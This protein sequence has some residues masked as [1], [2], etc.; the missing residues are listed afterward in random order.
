MIV[1]TFNWRPLVANVAYN[2]CTNTG[3]YSIFQRS[4]L[5]L[6]NNYQYNCNNTISSVSVVILF[7]W[8]GPSVQKVLR[9]NC[10]LCE[11]SLLELWRQPYHLRPQ[12]EGYAAGVTTRGV[13]PHAHVNYMVFFLCHCFIKFMFINKILMKT[14]ISF[15][16]LGVTMWTTLCSTQ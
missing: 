16:I 5:L 2:R 7:L 1:C 9:E 3:F 8:W 12:V 13:C 4:L 6:L 11:E 14:R 10:L 15:F